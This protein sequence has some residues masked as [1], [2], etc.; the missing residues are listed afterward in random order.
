MSVANLFNIPNTDQEM[1][2]WSFQHMAHHRLINL[3]ILRIYNV[4][5][6]EYVLDPVDMTDP[7]QFLLQHQKMHDA[8]D[9]VLGVSSFD[10]T[11]VDWSDQGQRA[12]W[13]WLNARL[14]VAEANATET[15]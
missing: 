1:G 5:L 6:P 9:G 4:V 3:A 10:L 8:S 12:G 15:F 11:D 14:H 2:T 13:I 7:V